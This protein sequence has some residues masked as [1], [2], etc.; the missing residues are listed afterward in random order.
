MERI[1][2]SYPELHQLLLGA[3]AVDKQWYRATYGDVAASGV[4]PVRHYIKY[5][6]LL[7][8]KP[9]PGFNTRHYLA[10]FPEVAREGLNPLAHYLSVFSPGAT[11][12]DEEAQPA[13]CLAFYGERVLEAVKSGVQADDAEALR[14]RDAV[15]SEADR[16]LSRRRGTVEQVWASLASL[17]LAGYLQEDARYWQAALDLTRYLF[18]SAGTRRP[19]EVDARVV[20]QDSGLLFAL[21]AVRLLKR[22]EYWT[23][24]DDQRL[25][26]WCERRLDA[27]V[28]AKDDLAQ[29]ADFWPWAWQT[30]ALQAFLGERDTLRAV[31]EWVVEYWRKPLNG[32]VS[33]ETA[34]R[35]CL[36][37]FV[38]KNTLGVDLER[39]APLQESLA[40]L[41]A[42]VSSD[43]VP[44]W[45]LNGY[46]LHQYGRL[47]NH[48]PTEYSMR[49]IRNHLL[50]HLWGGLSEPAVAALE[51]IVESARYRNEARVQAAREL[52]RWYSFEGKDTLAYAYL[53]RMRVFSP[54]VEQ[55]RD[56][57]LAAAFCEMRFDRP[58]KARAALE[59][60]LKHHPTDP[61]GLLALATA[62]ETEEERLACIN[63]MYANAGCCGITKKHQNQPLS[64]ANIV[65][66][67]CAPL[68]ECREKVTVIIPAYKAED[69]LA[70]A[71]ES[72]LAQTWHNLQIIIVD[73]CSPDGTFALAQCLAQQDDRVL[74]IKQEKNGGAYRARN[75]GLKHA[76]GDFITTHDSDDWSHP[77]KIEAQ[78][79][80]FAEHPQ[81]MGLT[82][83]WIR[84]RDDLS[85]TQNWRPGAKLIHISQSSF[86]FRRQVV[87]DIGEWDAV[88][89]G[90]DNEYIGRLRAFYG[91][92]AYKVIDKHVPYAFALDDESSLTRTKA[93]HVRTVYSGVRHVYKQIWAW[94]QTGGAK[95]G[96]KY[97]VDLPAKMTSR[98][99]GTLALGALLLLDCTSSTQLAEARS[100]IAQRNDTGLPVGVFHW[101]LFDYPPAD[102][103]NDYFELLS[104]AKGVPVVHGDRVLAEFVASVSQENLAHPV[105]AFPEVTAR[106]GVFCVRDEREKQA[107]L[108][109]RY[110]Y[111]D[112]QPVKLVTRERLIE[113]FDQSVGSR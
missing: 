69:R 45:A 87:A 28:T 38:A 46:C 52:S 56:W 90:G 57:A 72:L 64:M 11:P 39:V 35:W 15:V 7:G 59:R 60:F 8:R 112:N 17:G 37:Y 86:I 16:W 79:A 93:T 10:F 19:T 50:R 58:D 53:E 55:Q 109:V 104:T 42:R 62:S 106:Q 113:L 97:D 88:R 13:S 32:P 23:E 77:Q 85:F 71:V 66:H 70:V 61:D 24:L 33:D 74:A 4:G 5:G 49:S 26:L 29:G 110:S 73:D 25:T 1:A 51:G 95:Q 40:E 105:D 6:A 12:A 3:N 68:A 96:A 108:K 80:H 41:Y 2:E 18:C 27:L 9:R 31:V 14:L 44:H 54:G 20:T 36:S 103:C 65:G 76:R 22:S 81:T 111:F 83:N 30:M 92:K 91:K 47:V 21:D 75:T 98:G 63:R 43:W 48:K 78:M 34:A 100:L 84:A 94:Q 82:A 99:N 107:E 67:G 101:P 89:I 102:F